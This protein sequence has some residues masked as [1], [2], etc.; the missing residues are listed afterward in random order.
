M[1]MAVRI[2]LVTAL[3]GP[4]GWARAQEGGGRRAR[5]RRPR[6]SGAERG[7]GA[8]G[9]RAG[10]GRARA[11]AG[12]ERRRTSTNAGPIVDEGDW[13]EA[14]ACSTVWTREGHGAPTPRSTGRP[15]ASAKLGGREAEALETL[16]ALRAEHPKSRWLKE[17][18]ALELEISQSAG[19]A[20]RPK[21]RPTRTSS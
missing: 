21:A 2:G 7:T 11:G 13:D 3:A 4:G 8:R 5:T 16:R 1:R 9:T 19:Q 17:A 15:I 18:K 6:A 12:R 20:P 14:A 10:E